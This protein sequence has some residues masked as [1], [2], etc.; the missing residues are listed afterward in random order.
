MSRKRK[1]AK[2]W[3]WG[4]QQPAN[5]PADPQ[6]Q[7]APLSPLGLLPASTMA[8]PSPA[9][10][11]MTELLT[12]EVLG[13]FMTVHL[14]QGP[15]GAVPRA[16][17]YHLYKEGVFVRRKSAVGEY[18]RQ[19][20]HWD[21]PLPAKP[22]D[23]AMGLTLSLPKVPFEVLGQ[24]LAFF[25]A[26]DT[27]YK[28]AEAYASVWWTG[29][30]HE[31]HMPTQRVSAA[32]VHHDMDFDPP[33]WLHVLDIHSH[34][35]K[36]GGFFS[37]GDNADECNR[38]QRL[39]GV[40]GKIDQPIPDC[41]WR[42]RFG[43][44]F[45]EL[46]IADIFEM[47]VLQ[48]VQ[49]VNAALFFAAGGST[50][51][52]MQQA[53]SYNPFA[54]GTFPAEWLDKVTE[55]HAAYSSGGY[56]YVSNA[57]WDAAYE[58]YTQHQAG[59]NATPTGGHVGSVYPSHMVKGQPTGERRWEQES[60]ERLAKLAKARAEDE[61]QGILVEQGGVLVRMKSGQPDEIV[62][63]APYTESTD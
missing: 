30:H 52:S 40:M 34:T 28:G 19:L 60:R 36:M 45:V 25:R 56:S 23:L 20:C 21:Q 57:K 39:Y 44:E 24:V 5:S 37:P 17:T 47:P 35:S 16:T 10:R 38:G 53:V 43:G 59:F 11:P 3:P 1:H 55:E 58:E 61:T 26:V 33:G 41:K 54:D 2:L 29:E 4:Q 42:A 63:Q 48:A 12:P 14:G 22:A 50:T 49:Q 6:R 15:A 13:Q 8:T 9:L 18:V 51:G 46:A 7:R 27:K 62:G 31:V 32:H